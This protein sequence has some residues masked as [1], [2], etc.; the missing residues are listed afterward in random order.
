MSYVASQFFQYSKT[1]P[2]KITNILLG[3]QNVGSRK[4]LSYN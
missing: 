2:F 1:N 4:D 3:P